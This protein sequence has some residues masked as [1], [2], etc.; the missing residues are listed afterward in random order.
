MKFSTEKISLPVSCKE[1]TLTL[2]HTGTLPA[3]SMGHN[4]VITDTSNVQTVATEGMS[5]G[6]AS[7]YLKPDDPRVYA[8]TKIIGGGESTS[9]TFSTAKM[10]VGGD[11]SFFCSFPGHWA[12]MKGK[13][14][15]K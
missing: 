10:Q 9:I 6:L 1:I 4:L 8:H 15:L 3:A 7:N 13:F 11:Y 2:N 12:I 14:E 5:A